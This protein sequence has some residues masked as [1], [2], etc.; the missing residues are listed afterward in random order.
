MNYRTGVEK[1]EIIC[2]CTCTTKA[3]ILVLIQDGAESLENIA[4]LTRKSRLWRL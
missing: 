1:K 4:Y 2:H 3:Q